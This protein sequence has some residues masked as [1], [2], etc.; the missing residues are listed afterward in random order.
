MAELSQICRA[1]RESERRQE[2][3]W[4]ATVMRVKGSA[5]RHPG[6]R[7]VFS[8]DEVL[9]GSVSGGC[10]EAGIARK[11]PW[12]ARERPTCIRF[13]GSREEEDEESPRG[14]G[15]DGVVDILLE[16]ASFDAPSAPLAVIED[17]LRGERRAVLVTVFESREPL[18]PVGARLTLD[19]VGRLS[20]CAL[21]GP[22]WAKLAQAAE[23]AMGEQRAVTRT[24]STDCCEALLEVIEPP[25]HLFVFGTGPDAVPLVELA[26]L[27]G[28]GVTVCDPSGRPIVRERFAGLAELH[29]GSVES[30]AT[31]LAARRIPIGV[32]M[33]HHYPTDQRALGVLLASHAPYI[34]VLG[35]QRRSERLLHELFPDPHQLANSDRARVRAPLGLD[36]GAETPA[37]IALSALAEVQAVLAGAS[38]VP[39]CERGSQPIHRPVSTLVPSALPE[40]ARTG[41]A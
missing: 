40:L 35:P 10:L 31:K 16:R 19:E 3:V 22:T 17:C 32:I 38:A 18:A 36:L 6:A 20:T 26:T 4:L 11:G 30:V 34:G 28:F 12:L 25:P 1:A 39:L 15:C 2:P 23:Q 29:V 37:Q 14:T 21:S 24:L 9:A 8:S 7:M 5:Y 13:D 33:S 27:L 41:T